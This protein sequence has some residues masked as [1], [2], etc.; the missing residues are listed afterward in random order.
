MR[1]AR[2]K[3]EEKQNHRQHWQ[4]QGCAADRPLSKQGS[5]ETPREE[6]PPTVTTRARRPPKR[7]PPLQQAE[8]RELPGEG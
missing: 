8:S 6:S 5:L 2:I 4:E 3:P 7:S 1:E